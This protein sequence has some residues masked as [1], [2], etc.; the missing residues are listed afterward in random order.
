MPMEEDPG[1]CLW[2]LR[3]QMQ[4]PTVHANQTPTTSVD[5]PRCSL[6]GLVRPSLCS[7]GSAIM[8]QEVEHTHTQGGILEA[9]C[10][11]FGTP[12]VEQGVSHRPGVGYV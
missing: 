11:Q 6:R 5:E 3:T 4:Y 1:G 2:L 12:V 10:E 8:S 9:R 7:T